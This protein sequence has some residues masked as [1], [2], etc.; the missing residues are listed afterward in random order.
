VK[1]NKFNKALKHLKSKELDKKIKDLDE[2]APTNS[3]SGVYQVSPS[4]GD[5]FRLGPKDPPK[6]F[7]PKADGSWPAG[8]PGDPNKIH[9]DRPA[10]YWNSGRNTV[11]PVGTPTDRDF[12]YADVQ[13]K[14]KT[15]TTTLIRASDGKP[16]TALPPNSE[17]F[18]LGPLCTSYAINHGYDDYTNLG[19]IQKDTRQFVLLA[20]IQGHFRGEDKPRTSY[21]NY[22]SFGRTW[23]GSAG[24][25]TIYNSNFTLE[26]AQWMKDTYLAGNYKA[27]FPFNFSGGI[28]VER[29]DD[30]PSM[31]DG[32]ILGTDEGKFS[33]D[34]HTDGQEQDDPDDTDL[35]KLNLWGLLKKGIETFGDFAIDPLGSIAD[36]F[37]EYL[38]PPAAEYATNIAKSVVTNKPITVKQEDIPKGD[39]DKFFK[40]FGYSS[41]LP[42]SNGKPTPYADENFYFD[43][44]GNVKSNIGPNGEKAY[45]KKNNTADMG[46]GKGVAGYGNPLAA[47]GQAQT[48][49]V[50]PDDGSEPYFLYTD[51]AYHNLTSDDK[52]EVP[53]PVKAALSAGLHAVTGKSDPTKPNT[54]GMSGYP[55]NVKGDVKTEFKIP[56]SKLPKN[57]K[58]RV[59]FERKYDELV[60][61]GKV[62]PITTTESFNASKRKILREVKRP[63]LIE[64]TPKT[65]KL[66]G[67][68]PNFKG[69]FSP[70]NTPDVTASK[71]SDE[72]VHG[73]NT[74]R[75]A[76][77]SKDKYWKGYETAERMNV[78]YDRVGF[79]DQ[80][81]D[82]VV[83]ENILGNKNKARKMQ[84]H[85]NTLA[86]EKALREVYGVTES[87]FR[88]IK[89][90]ETYD[91]KVKDPLFTKVASRLKKEI[92]YPKKPSPN[93]YPSEAPPK[94]DPNTG[95]HPKYGKRYKYDKLDP[96]SAEAM[97]MQGDPEI[98]ANIQR[99]SDKKAKARKLKN[100]M[101]KK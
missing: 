45:Y 39:I 44:K 61:S 46:G 72:A 31:G 97:P 87:P 38:T 48:Q 100:L 81:F 73:Y 12:S 35:E 62:K 70:Q 3:M 24:D 55:P 42:I 76:W 69:K 84:E 25:L 53:D 68:K 14:G 67:Y 92:D 74:S 85:L 16:Y 28:P 66:K 13:A 59:D 18:I 21:L 36:F 98:D 63:V 29:N 40:N 57:I 1:R 78:I 96:Q 65:T 77:T 33:D 32:E 43:E 5:A 64:A 89:E 75:L 7:Y 90:S 15:D 34:D 37:G 60:K 79:G 83:A 54:G 22:G 88:N 71:K 56:Y 93:G 30:D 9:Y 95:M 99:L 4:S 27:N 50:V 86:H 11:Q 91:N 51:H 47:A 10:G 26:M 58:D 94:I 19:Y 6:R 82:K 8:I 49:F 52:G 101:G 80:Y 2:A 41:P 17:S 20:R 23:D